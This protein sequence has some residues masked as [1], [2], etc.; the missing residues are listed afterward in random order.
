VSC[1]RIFT[2]IILS[3]GAIFLFL[4]V[5]EAISAEL[6]SPLSGTVACEGFAYTIDPDP[7]GLNVRSGPQKESP[8]L[9]VI[10][11]DPEG[12]AVTLAGS[13]GDW[14]LVR[15]AQGLTSGFESQ[16]EGW[17]YS[18][19]LAVRAVHPSGRKVPLYSRPDTKSSVLK[20][21]AGETEARLAGCKGDWLQVRIGSI[22]GWLTRSDYCGNPVTTCP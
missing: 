3:V 11:Y 21:V 6:T 18:P 4:P 16:K 2:S 20:I 15:S 9:F 1:I 17:V 7:R 14:V 8:V 12:T 10:P 19:L 13:F 5:P 22:K